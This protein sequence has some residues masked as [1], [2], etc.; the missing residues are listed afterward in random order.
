MTMMVV[1]IVMKNRVAAVCE[2]VCVQYVK[3]CVYSMKVCVYSMCVLLKNR[4][5]EQM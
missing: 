3:V 2:S 4:E 5:N 1:M